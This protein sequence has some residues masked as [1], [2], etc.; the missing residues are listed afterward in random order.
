[1]RFVLAR[2]AGNGTGVVP[3]TVVDCSNGGMGLEVNYFF[4]RG[5]EL[6]VRVEPATGVESGGWLEAS[7]IVQRVTMLSRAPNYYIGLAFKGDRSP[8]KPTVDRLLDWAMSAP[9][10]PGALAGMNLEVHRVRA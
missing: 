6:L 10:T 5:A 1:M 2:A 7:G 3:A 4:P 8:P 9:A